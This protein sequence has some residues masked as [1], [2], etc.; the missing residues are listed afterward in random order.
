MEN[1]MWDE[2]IYLNFQNGF[3]ME[4]C[5]VAC[6]LNFLNYFSIEKCDVARGDFFELFELFFNRESLHGMR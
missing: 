4:K 6:T 5:D 2:V 3:S 1:V